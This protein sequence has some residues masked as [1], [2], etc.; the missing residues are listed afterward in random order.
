MDSLLQDLRTQ[1]ERFDK[2]ARLCSY[3]AI[4]QTRQISI[5]NQQ[6]LNDHVDRSITQWDSFQNEI[7]SGQASTQQEIHAMQQYL[8]GVV[9]RFLGS[10]DSVDPKTG[11]GERCLKESL[12][13][14]LIRDSAIVRGPMLPSDKAATE[15][16]ALQSEW[17]CMSSSQHP[18]LI[19]T[20]PSV[21]TLSRPRLR[22][23]RLYYINP[24]S[25][26]N[27]QSR[28]RLEASPAIPGPCHRRHAE[29]KTAH[30]DHHPYLLH[31]IHKHE[32]TGYISFF[33][34]PPRQ[35]R[36]VH[37]YPALR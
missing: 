23:S 26:L 37:H 6:T 27:N 13:V 10:H 16:R 19:E 32:H 25:R 9:E 2:A 4:E 36:P 5:Q 29:P 3:E 15:R 24:R 34:I 31:P 22:G 21:P 11:N 12:V 8:F 1:S 28:Q 18:I 20:N 14:R 30:L 33:V 17:P 35:T 7:R